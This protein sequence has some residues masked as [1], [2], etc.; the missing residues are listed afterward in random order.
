MTHFETE[1]KYLL[2]LSQLVTCETSA[3]LVLET[4][5]E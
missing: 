5:K 1:P 4:N 2:G 3:L